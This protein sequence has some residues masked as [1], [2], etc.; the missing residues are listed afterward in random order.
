MFDLIKDLAAHTVLDLLFFDVLL[1]FT[2]NFNLGHSHIYIIFHQKTSLHITGLWGL[3]CGARSK[4]VFLTKDYIRMALPFSKIP[5]KKHTN[6]RIDST[7]TPQ[8]WCPIAWVC[9]FRKISMIEFTIKL[10]VRVRMIRKGEG[11]ICKRCARP[12]QFTQPT[13]LYPSF[14]HS[15]G[16]YVLIIQSNIES[17]PKMIQFKI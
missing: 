9:T 7:F 8:C 17:G 13:L 15:P 3:Q 4:D 12:S 16:R 14:P 11:L 1:S 5:R 2:V 6:V 10:K